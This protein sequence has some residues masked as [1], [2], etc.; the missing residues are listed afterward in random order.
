MWQKNL[1]CI[2]HFN[3]GDAQK[4]FEEHGSTQQ[5]HS[6]GYKFFVEGFIHDVW[7]NESKPSVKAKCFH[8]QKR[9]E[10]PH[11]LVLEFRKENDFLNLKECHC[12]CEVG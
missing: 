4:F 8:S 1:Q 3:F 10:K 12:S 5:Q 9:N 2:K 7:I 11:N 6:R